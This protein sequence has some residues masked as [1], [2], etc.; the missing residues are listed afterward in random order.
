[1]ST[2]DRKWEIIES[3]YLIR[4]PWLTARRDRVKL[5]TGVEI[6]EYLLKHLV[7][8]LLLMHFLLDRQS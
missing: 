7:L 5:P 8:F 2:D 6:P 3:E 1:M 4:R